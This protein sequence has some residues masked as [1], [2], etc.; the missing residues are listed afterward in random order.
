MSVCV[1]QLDHCNHQPCL[2]YKATSEDAQSF[3]L[4][5]KLLKKSAPV[6]Q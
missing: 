1:A 3:A 6:S 2:N 5:R 4:G